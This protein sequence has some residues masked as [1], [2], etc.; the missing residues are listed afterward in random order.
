MLRRIVKE[1]SASISSA[2]GLFSSRMQM[3]TLP[4]A[5]I[6]NKFNI[7]REDIKGVEINHL[8]WIVVNFN[9]SLQHP[10][11]IEHQLR[12]ADLE[13]NMLHLLDNSCYSLIYQGNKEEFY[14]FIKSPHSADEPSPGLK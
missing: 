13:G 3:K 14:A 6:A 7:H 11:R 5:T 1:S 2:C 8:G 12:D 10:Q 4:I 9:A